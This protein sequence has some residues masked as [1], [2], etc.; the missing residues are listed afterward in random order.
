MRLIEHRGAVRMLEFM[1]AAAASSLTIR[2]AP[3]ACSAAQSTTV[4][5]EQAN[6]GRVF[7]TSAGGRMSCLCRWF[8]NAVN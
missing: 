7:A 5:Y 2:S 6:D 4:D 8:T 3:T 1:L